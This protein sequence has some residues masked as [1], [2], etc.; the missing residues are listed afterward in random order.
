MTNDLS[1]EDFWIKGAGALRGAGAVFAKAAGDTQNASGTL[2]RRGIGPRPDE[3]KR[4]DTTVKMVIDH[5][6]NT[7]Q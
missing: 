4:V 6:G 2:S 1:D 7:Q 3:R 5:F